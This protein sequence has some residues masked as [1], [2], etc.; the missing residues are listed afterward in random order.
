MEPSI[1]LPCSLESATHSCSDLQCTS[2]NAI[3]LT[4]FLI[5]Y[6]LCL[7][8]PNS[9]F[10][11]GLPVKILYTFPVSPCTLHASPISSSWFYH[12]SNIWWCIQIIQ[13]SLSSCLFIFL[14]LNTYLSTLFSNTL[15]LCLSLNIR[16]HVWH[17]CKTT[18]K[19]MLYFNLYVLD[20]RQK[21]KRY[22]T[23]WE[24]ASSYLMCP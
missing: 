10:S 14:D 11:L 4:Y 8:L 6:H 20:S 19:I 17:P 5:F 15:N 1:L 18:S 7:G 24:Q 13:C 21:D 22:W 2:C 12:P 3:C 16:D 9:L 23:A